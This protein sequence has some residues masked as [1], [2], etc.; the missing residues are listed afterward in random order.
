MGSFAKGQKGTSGY[1]KSKHKTTKELDEIFN[2]DRSEPEA[3]AVDD[4]MAQVEREEEES[5][6]ITQRIRNIFEN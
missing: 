3:N 2:E 4:G 6:G 1:L 5:R